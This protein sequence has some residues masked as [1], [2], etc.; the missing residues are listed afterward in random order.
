VWNDYNTLSVSLETA[1]ECATSVRLPLSPCR[2]ICVPFRTRASIVHFAGPIPAYR[3]AVPAQHGTT[4]PYIPPIQVRPLFQNRHTYAWLFC[5]SIRLSCPH[6]FSPP[7]F[8][9]QDPRLLVFLPCGQHRPTRVYAPGGSG[10]AGR[11]HFER[12]APF[13]PG[14]PFEPCRFTGKP[15]DRLVLRDEW[16]AGSGRTRP[17]SE[18]KNPQ[19]FTLQET[20]WRNI[21]G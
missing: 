20:K 2:S 16:K 11:S 7:R 4:G 13:L 10:K 1:P 17:N 14:Y 18:L 6:T 19:L 5:Q 8:A 15:A 21:M 12:A 3:L 9:P